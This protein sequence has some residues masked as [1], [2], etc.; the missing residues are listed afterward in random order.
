[1]I[2][3]LLKSLLLTLFKAPSGPPEP[4]AGS[5]DSVKV[6]RA[7]KNY[8]FYKLVQLGIVAAFFVGFW[9]IV[10]IATLLD[11]QTPRWFTHLLI[12][13]GVLILIG[14]AVA[15]FLTR[16]E[17]DMRY[18]IITDRSLRIREG[19]LVIKEITLTYANVQH[20]EIK[21]GPI[22]QLLGISDVYVRTAGG[23]ATMVQP[24]QQGLLSALAQPVGRRAVLRG[25][26]NASAI[27]DQINALLKRYRHAGLGDPEERQ[28]GR[29]SAFSPLAIERLREIRDALRNWRHRLSSG[30]IQNLPGSSM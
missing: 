30:G 27:R 14:I 28:R 9:L 13:I 12:V 2:Y 17:Y 6:F 3:N 18:Y 22:Q 24:H 1:M 16:L 5:P 10:L 11:R 21:Q 15:Y 19:V 8:L 26:D 23:G 29:T 25:V 20:L 4:P 7:S